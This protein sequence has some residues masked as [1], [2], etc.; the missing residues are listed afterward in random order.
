MSN[1]TFT[2]I[3][4]FLIEIDKLKTIFRKSHHLFND[5]HEN[6]AEHSWHAA[7]A[8]TI[9]AEHIDYEVDVLKVLKMLLIH[10][11][12][13]MDVQDVFCMTMTLALSA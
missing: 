7:I 8:A 12:A 1:K 10:D 13:E 6:S 9:L 2:K 11:L 4:N 3:I 5:M